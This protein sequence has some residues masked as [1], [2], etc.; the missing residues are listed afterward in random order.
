[1]CKKRLKKLLDEWVVLAD[2]EVVDV[3]DE[4]EDGET[5]GANPG[6]PACS[7]TT[8]VESPGST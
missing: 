4:T 3:L 8:P 5:T 7:A 1:M 2:C 6:S